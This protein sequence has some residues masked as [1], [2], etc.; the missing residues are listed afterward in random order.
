M[1]CPYPSE[2][3]RLRRV[4]SCRLLNPHSLAIM[5]GCQ[6]LRVYSQFP[7]HQTSPSEMLAD[8]RARHRLKCLEDELQ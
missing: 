4:Q 8:N 2:L 5:V 3:H 6:Y 1:N 7:H